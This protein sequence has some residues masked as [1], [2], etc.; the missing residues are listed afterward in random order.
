[1]SHCVINNEKKLL[2][3][4]HW[5]TKISKVYK[6]INVYITYLHLIIVIDIEKIIL[7]NTLTEMLSDKLSNLIYGNPMSIK[8]SKY[9]F[10]LYV[11]QIYNTRTKVVSCPLI[12]NI[13]RSSLRD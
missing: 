9:I 4:K 2:K 8:R 3:I 6:K 7:F 12:K 10:S 5:A 11:I 1:M 13:R